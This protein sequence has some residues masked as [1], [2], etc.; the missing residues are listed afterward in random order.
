MPGYQ[1][2][3]GRAGILMSHSN[4]LDEP[5]LLVEGFATKWGGWSFLHLHMG[6]AT[7]LT[8]R[9]GARPALACAHTREPL[10]ARLPLRYQPWRRPRGKAGCWHAHG[11]RARRSHTI[12]APPS[13]GPPQPSPQD[14]RRDRYWISRRPF[15]ALRTPGRCRNLWD[16]SRLIGRVPLNS[17]TRH[18]SPFKQRARGRAPAREE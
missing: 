15:C 3:C 11:T 14:G 1:Y 12:S 2:D 10:C 16:N 18:R 9:G 13:S 8:R 17:R 6:V 7:L 4:R 5:S